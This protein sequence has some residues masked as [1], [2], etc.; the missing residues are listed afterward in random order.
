VVLDLARSVRTVGGRVLRRAGVD[1]VR[2]ASLRHPLGRRRQLLK[3]L[4]VDLVIDVGANDGEYG[5]ELRRIGYRGRIV[6]FEPLREPFERLSR[7][8]H[9]DAQWHA[10]QSAIGPSP[11][12]AD[13]NVAANRGASSSFLSMLQKHVDEA[14]DATYVGTE[15][16][17]IRRL[18]EACREDVLRTR[19][20]FLK[21]DV[22]GFELQVLESAVGILPNIAGLQLEMSLVSL[23][24][25]APSFKA[26]IERTQV[27]GFDLVGLEPGFAAADGRLLQADGLFERSGP[28]T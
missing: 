14:P 28:T 23:Y 2:V 3:A 13:L 17:V 12:H 21:A 11:G 5:S 16:V 22:Q 25:G 10:I 27:L 9:G 1:P 24:S 7:R 26:V 20:A 4:R 18:D 8:A 19:A 6:S 15:R